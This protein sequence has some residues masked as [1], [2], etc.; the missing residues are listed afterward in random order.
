MDHTLAKLAVDAAAIVAAAAW[1]A[2]AGRHSVWPWLCLALCTLSVI[3][4]H[5]FA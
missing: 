1:F 3:A 2:T 4:V 5:L